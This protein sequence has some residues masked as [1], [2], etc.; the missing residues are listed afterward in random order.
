[1]SRPQRCN[2]C[3][4]PIWLPESLA[5]QCCAECRALIGPRIPAGLSAR[6][7]ASVDERL[8]QLDADAAVLGRIT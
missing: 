3:Q 4:A 6:R 1:M 8:R 7:R 2:V 5:A